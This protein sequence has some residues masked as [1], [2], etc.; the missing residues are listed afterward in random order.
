MFPLT[1]TVQSALSPMRMY[2]YLSDPS[3]NTVVEN[4]EGVAEADYSKHKNTPTDGRAERRGEA[5]RGEG[6]TKRRVD[7]ETDSVQSLV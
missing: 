7:S 5:R 3:G 1:P 6:G 2:R 4:V